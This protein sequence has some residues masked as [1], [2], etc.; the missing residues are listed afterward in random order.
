MEEINNQKAKTKTKKNW[1]HS[2]TG[3]CQFF[4]V[5]HNNE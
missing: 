2:S 4:D 3:S 5:I 1:Q